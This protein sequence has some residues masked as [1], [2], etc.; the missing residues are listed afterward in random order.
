MF[1]HLLIP[2]DG[3]PLAE[4]ALSPARLLAD[5]LGCSVTLIHIV[6]KNAPAEIHGERHLTS[7][8]EAC[9]YLSEIAERAF[10]P[11][12]TVKRHVHSEEV[13]D[14]ARSITQHATEEFTPDLI[15]MCAHG[16]GGLRDL[17]VGSIAQQVI[18]Q[19]KTPVLL[20]QPGEGVNPTPTAFTRFL[21]GLDAVPEHEASLTAGAE[22]A[23]ALGASLVLANVV[24]TMETLRGE[25]AA[26]GKLLPATTQAMLEMT[27]TSAQEYLEMLAQPLRERGLDVI[28]RVGRGGVPKELASLAV[29][30]DCDLLVLGTHGRAGMGAFWSGSV[31][32]RVAGQTHLPILFVPAHMG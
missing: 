24:N 26:T 18:G 12:T 29:E 28:T 3:S 19:G 6:E 17:M 7:E 5:R 2:L 4:A 13:R 8:D 25:R 22:L 32:P 30:S 16:H 31:A 21:I 20:I 11:A 27:V 14:V 15:V 1:K 23:E 9:Q 10:D